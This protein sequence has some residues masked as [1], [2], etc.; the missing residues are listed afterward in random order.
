M[1]HPSL[2][3]EQYTKCALLDVTVRA[4]EPYRGSSYDDFGY[5]VSRGENQKFMWT[6]LLCVAD[7]NTKPINWLTKSFLTID[8]ALEAAADPERFGLGWD[9]YA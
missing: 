1:R 3:L 7:E 9:N 2:T 6:A 4:Y 5:F 8:E